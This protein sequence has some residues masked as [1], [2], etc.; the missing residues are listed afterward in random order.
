[1][2]GGT[3]TRPLGGR[4]QRLALVLGGVLGLAVAIGIAAYARGGGDGGATPAGYQPVVVASQDIPAGTRITADMLEPKSV[5]VDEAVADAFTSRGAVVD[6]VSAQAIAAGEQVVPAMVSTEGGDG[7]AFKIQPGMRAVS[8]A[9]EEA[10]IAG[11]NAR[12]GDRVDVVAVFQVSTPE[13][14]RSILATFAGDANAAALPT[15]PQEQMVAGCTYNITGTLV[16]NLRLVAVAQSL[17]AADATAEGTEETPSGDA[18]PRASTATLEVTPD[19]AQLLALADQYGANRLTVRPFG[20]E[21]AVSLPW[22]V[23]VIDNSLNVR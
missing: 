3:I 7:L 19:Q 11:G 9:V 4:S 16:Q 23:T 21:Q 12:P 18:Q 10:V 1:M 6:R 13:A 5:P 17:A 22:R 20:D 8:I 2:A 14:V 15:C